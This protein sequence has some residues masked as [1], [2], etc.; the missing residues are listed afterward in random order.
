MEYILSESV[1]LLID[2]VLLS[3]VTLALLMGKDKSQASDSLERRISNKTP[4]L[5]PY[6]SGSSRTSCHFTLYQ[7]Q[8]STH[9]HLSFRHVIWIYNFA[10]VRCD[11]PQRWE[12]YIYIY[13]YGWCHQSWRVFFTVSEIF[14]RGNK[15]G[16]L[17]GR[18]SQEWF[19]LQ[20]SL[21]DCSDLY[22]CMD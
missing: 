8:T 11:C 7:I 12:I 1:I 10:T 17:Q 21:T 5:P 2:I 9:M 14:I 22:K 19:N 20:N 13:I 15:Y 3:C 6:C 16:R 4:K 18:Y